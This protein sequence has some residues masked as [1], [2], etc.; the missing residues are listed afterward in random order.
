MK[1][2]LVFYFLIVAH[3]SFS[4]NYDE[5]GIPFIRNYTTKEYNAG[6]QNWDI[7]QDN[8][9]L[10]YFGNGDNGLL[11][12]D[13]TSWETIPISCN[14]VARS[15]GIDST[16]RIYIGSVGDFG[17]L[18]PD[19]LGALIYH[20]FLK[21]YPQIDT[22]FTDIW[23][24]SIT[25]NGVYFL[26]RDILVRYHK[27]KI[28]TWHPKINNFF[29]LYHVDNKLFVHELGYGL[30]E[31]V[32]NEL[33]LIPKS[34]I[35]K[36]EKI[37]AI[38]EYDKN[39]LLIYTRTM[40]LYIYNLDSK[41][42]KKFSTEIDNFL[43]RNRLYCALTLSNNNFAIGTL[44]GGI[45]IID[46]SGKLVQKIN[47]SKGLLD[48]VI[49][50]IYEDKQNSLWIGQSNG[51]SRID[52]QYPLTVFNNTNCL[53]SSVLSTTR[54]NNNIYIA[55]FEGIY[56]LVNNNFA[57]ID[58]FGQSWCIVDYKHPK[59]SQSTIL[60]GTN[61]GVY[62]F[63][64]NKK[65]HI[66]LHSICFNIFPSKFYPNRIYIPT[67]KGLELLKFSNGEFNYIG[68][69]PGFEH[70]IKFFFEEKNG[71]L[72]V[73]SGFKNIS[74]ISF[75]NKNINSAEI[76]SYDKNSGL[77]NLT[78]IQV[79]EFNNK[80]IFAT[81]DG[82]YS[83]NKSE[84]RFFREEKLSE[85][86]TD[87]HQPIYIAQEDPNK[88]IWISSLNTKE[89][90]LGYLK[91]ISD[92]TY[93]WNNT[94]FNRIP[95]ISI[96]NIY[97]DKNGITWIGGADGLIRYDLY[98][99][100]INYNK[101]YNTL[102]RKVKINNDSIIF[103]G[104]ATKENSTIPEINYKNN[105]L[106]FYYSSTFYEK[107]DGIKYQYKL[108]GYDKNWSKNSLQTFKEYTNL[109]FGEYI[110]TVRAINSFKNYSTIAQ[111]RFKILKPWY[112]TIIAYIS[113]IL[114]LSLI[115][116]FL[117]KSYTIK[118]KKSNKKLEQIIIQ[119]TS[120]INKQKEELL[121]Q[122]KTLEISNKKLK[123]LSIAAKETDNA[124]MIFSDK[125]KI[126]WINEGFTRLYGYT[127]EDFSEEKYKTLIYETIIPK[128]KQ[129]IKKCISIKK[130]TIYEALNITKTKTKIWTQRTLTPIINDDNK[131]TKFIAIDSDI[132]SIKMAEM[133]ILQQ[134]DE[135]EAQHDFSRLQ[136][137]FIEQQNTE[138]EKHRNNL[139]KLVEKRTKD[140][141]IAKEKAEESDKLKSAFLANMSHE[142]RTP[143]N[144]IIGFSNLLTDEDL[145]T[146]EKNE[147]HQHIIQNS[148]TLLQ[149]IND[150]IDIAK[151]EAE[152][153]KIEKQQFNIKTTFSDLFNVFSTKIKQL[154]KDNIKLIIANDVINKDLEL[155]TDPLRVKQ[156]LTNLI[157]N[158]IKFT[159]NGFVEFGYN[160]LKDNNSSSIIRF[161]VK[162]SGIGLTKNQQ[163]EIFKRFGKIEINK[164]KLYRGS[165]L[166]LAICKNLV[167]LL[168]GSI[169]LSSEP[170]NGSTFYFTL[171]YSNQISDKQNVK[172][173]LISDNAYNWKNKTILIAE[174][175]KSNIR[176]LEMLFKKSQA[177]LIIVGN[178]IEAINQCKENNPDI[179]L[180]DIKMPILDGLS[181]TKE[182]RK[183]NT[184]IPIIAQTAFAMENDRRICL[185]SGCDNYI[186]KP[187]TKDKLFSIISMY[188]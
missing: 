182:I 95:Q 33:V 181:A 8:N 48:N 120:K 81:K 141:E 20:S 11:E 26:A 70:S 29:F 2:L 21:E 123:Q 97:N 175:E 3:L 34:T 28:Q 147:L 153:L 118:L 172:N 124:V 61:T 114:L 49:Y 85:F 108:E 23:N 127:L 93:K 159:D 168:G 149:L 179:I 77:K 134:K 112:H 99:D 50:S 125:G 16:N 110:F 109:R 45:A 186:S 58:D 121:N 115:I 10:M 67:R 104:T 102:I 119:R 146:N 152:Q 59:S 82:L 165:G 69:I 39:N 24:I 12:Y 22:N 71:N 38:S 154:N 183:F 128:I 126:E 180:M 86:L 160:I 94:V 107:K 144:A 137:E 158:A 57:Q 55:T 15:I 138:L 105:S 76:T 169:N 54:I 1:K 170:N 73:S 143:M 161:Y 5:T 111:Y 83:F 130:S 164:N 122:S 150:I 100:T 148:H 173:M 167:E 6:P 17:Y 157:D 132:T 74:H 188:I 18:K 75:K 92:S 13:G 36:N 44:L 43:N 56:K 90:S 106:T 163:Q 166:G 177:K 142:I 9:G 136:K 91:R 41:T 47:R 79:S 139:E 72:W 129:N 32:N 87:K 145:D 89:Y 176:Y 14:S 46:K 31:M 116:Y 52:I 171:P 25:K 60:I 140:L 27:N 184:T 68:K 156:I 187:I 42:F 35:F 53:N 117:I 151:I 7:A 84:N 62:K 98:A 4:Q 135:I 64:N 80:T 40:G 66:A 162:D 131:I 30:M 88:N 63:E 185:A 51:I 178:G 101:P 96:Y 133:E 174:D 37:Y 113:Y 65:K 19:S 103:Y 155:Y 78:E